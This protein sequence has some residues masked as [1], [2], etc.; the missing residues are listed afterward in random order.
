MK[1]PEGQFAVCVWDP[2][3][4]RKSTPSIVETETTSRDAIYSSEKYACWYAKQ[5]NKKAE[6]EYTAMNPRIRVC[7]GETEYFVVND[8]GNRVN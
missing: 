2:S 3:N 4:P 7:L 8:Q 1:A 6:Q 5:R